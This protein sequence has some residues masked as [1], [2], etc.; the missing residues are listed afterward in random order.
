MAGRRQLQKFDRLK[1]L[2]DPA[3]ACLRET[4][5][6]QNKYD[7]MHVISHLCNNQEFRKFRKTNHSLEQQPLLLKELT[8]AHE[9]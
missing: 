8:P 1:K 6:H 9:L 7:T 2:E 5:S 3:L 4:A